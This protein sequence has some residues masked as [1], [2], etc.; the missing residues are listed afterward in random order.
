M[1]LGAPGVGKGT[2]AELLSDALG[3]CALSMGDVLRTAR[4]APQR[5][6]A[7]IAAAAFMERGELVPDETVLE[8]LAERRGCLRCGAGLGFLLDGFPRTVA[9][10][11]A[12]EVLLSADGAT[13]DAVV[14]YELPIETIVTRLAGRRVCPGCKAIYHL[15]AHPPRQSGQCDQCGGALVQRADDE[16]QAIRTRMAAYDRST[17]PLADFYRSRGLLLSIPAEGTP[18]EIVARTLAA[19]T[20]G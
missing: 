19:L 12:L 9:Q 8:V 11:E 18:E 20:P 2:Q 4:T 17:R 16:P 3:A 1:L 5:S 14:S 13:L 6:P 7:I 10:A 15:D